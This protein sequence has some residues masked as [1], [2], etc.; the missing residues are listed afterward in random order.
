M[1]HSV[2][3]YVFSYAQTYITVIQNQL[4]DIQA[5]FRSKI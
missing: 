2:N 3:L 4:F 5:I 1:N